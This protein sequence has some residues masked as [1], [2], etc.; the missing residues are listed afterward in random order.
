MFAKYRIYMIILYYIQCTHA[1]TI[2]VINDHEAI[3]DLQTIFHHDAVA[4]FDNIVCIRC[5][6]PVA[7]L[8]VARILSRSYYI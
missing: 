5:V 8:M 7:E 6:I 1:C 4:V 2:A 3:A